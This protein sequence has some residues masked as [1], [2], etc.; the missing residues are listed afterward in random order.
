MPYKRTHLTE[1]SQTVWTEQHGP[2]V[3]VQT[4]TKGRQWENSTVPEKGTPIFSPSFTGN[5]EGYSHLTLASFCVNSQRL[6]RKYLWGTLQNHTAGSAD[7]TALIW[8]PF[9]LIFK[10]T[11]GHFVPNN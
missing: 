7:S 11:M 1:H 2:H 4:S 5:W 3:G 9:A 10:T 8:V 6:N